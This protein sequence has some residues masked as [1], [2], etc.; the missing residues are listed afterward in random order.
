MSLLTKNTT[1]AER[2]RKCAFSELFVNTLSVVENNGTITGTPTINN[3]GT[4]SGTGEYIDYPLVPSLNPLDFTMT[5]DFEFTAGSGT[6]QILAQ[7][8][9]GVSTN[10]SGAIVID[11]ADKVRFSINN[12]VAIYTAGA[13]TTGR[14]TITYRYGG[15]AGASRATAVDGVEYSLSTTSGG[16][17]SATAGITI[18]AE[19][20]HT[21]LFTGTIYSVKLFSNQ[22]TL[23]EHTDYYN[24][25]T[26]DYINDASVNL[27]MTFDANDSTNTRTLDVSGND[28][29][30][31]WTAGATQPT[32][33]T[34][35]KGFSFDGGDHLV[36]SGFRKTDD[37]AFSFSAWCRTSSTGTGFILGYYTAPRYCTLWFQSGQIYCRI[38]Q[39]S[40]GSLL[41]AST[42]GTYNDGNWHHV[43]F[44]FDGVNKLELFVDGESRASATGAFSSF[45]ADSAFF[46]GA[47][48]NGGSPANLFTGD[49][50]NVINWTYK[51]TPMRIKD[52]YLRE[53]KQ[54]NDK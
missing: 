18:G 27:P 31:T 6:T 10:N 29:H 53:L 44:T 28:Y 30:A 35:Y 38:G 45:F 41:T 42:T 14:H 39:G 12:G 2:E 11:N 50:Q 37:T 34:R 47:S 33:L 4:F 54:V 32:K 24:N 20:D 5:I 51:L 3:G 1:P 36:L 9:D 19:T 17:G 40:G 26:Y 52:I 21:N 7:W 46:I 48:N 13:L 49:I 23:Q 43:F 16:A 22:L 8:G 25:T 15:G